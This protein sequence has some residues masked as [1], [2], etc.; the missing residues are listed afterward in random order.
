MRGLWRMSTAEEIAEWINLW[1]K[2]QN[3]QLTDVPDSI[4][5]R[6]TTDGVYTSKSAYAIQFR[7]SFCT[8]HSKAVW[9]AK[10]EGKHK[11]FAWLLVQNKILTADKLLARNW[12]CNPVCCLCEQAEETTPHLCLH[13][14]YA[15]RCFRPATY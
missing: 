14:V 9:S 8:F 13:C 1:E 15:C 4:R 7:G 3:V 5:C 2:L 6:W 10:A 11:V 12:P